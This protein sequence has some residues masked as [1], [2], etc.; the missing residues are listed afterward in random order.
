MFEF[1][2]CEIGVSGGGLGAYLGTCSANYSVNCYSADVMIDYSPRYNFKSAT[3]FP[4]APASSEDDCGSTSVAFFV[5][6]Y[7][8]QTV[9]P[10]FD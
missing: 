4:V 6:A 9:A 2:F 8:A 1:L 7:S 10:S 3:V 5:T